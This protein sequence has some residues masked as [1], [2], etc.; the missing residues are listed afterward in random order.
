MIVIREAKIT[1]KKGDTLI[2]SL[3][4]LP[5]YANSQTVGKSSKKTVVVKDYST[6]NSSWVVQDMQTKGF[7]TLSK[8]LSQLNGSYP[9][10]SRYDV[11]DIKKK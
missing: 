3:Y 7:Y 4:R 6:V 5:V 2:L 1:V 10:P 9:K 8:N 11:E